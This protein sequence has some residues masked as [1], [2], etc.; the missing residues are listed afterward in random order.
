MQIAKREGYTTGATGGHFEKRPKLENIPDN[1][2][3]L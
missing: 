3:L 2:A 1:L